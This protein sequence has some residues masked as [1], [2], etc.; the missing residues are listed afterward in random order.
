MLL[1]KTLLERP[2]AAMPVQTHA[3]RTLST[4]GEPASRA[5]YFDQSPED[6]DT[7]EKLEN[8]EPDQL[9]DTSEG[10]ISTKDFA[11]DQS[12]PLHHGY[13][14]GAE[15]YYDEEDMM[16]DGDE[17]INEDQGK[18]Q[19]IILPKDYLI[20]QLAVALYDFE[21]ENDNEL[22]LREG[23]VVFISYR[24]GQGWLVAENQER[25]KTGLVPEDFV[26]YLEDSDD[27]EETAET[28]RPFYLTQFIT[29]GMNSA[30]GTEDARNY[31]DDDHEDDEEWEDVDHLEEEIADKLNIS[32]K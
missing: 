8:E 16:C 17:D 27:G 15:D 23:D 12:N 20:N 24:H 22:G 31:D 4:S 26:T 25:T 29:Q 2:T 21:P 11:Y 5:K 7:C 9:D 13:L 18:R 19:S 10:Y 1:H 32:N 3:D 30:T 6:H 14:Q 28:A